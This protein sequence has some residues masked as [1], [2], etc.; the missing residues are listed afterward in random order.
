VQGR[1]PWNQPQLNAGGQRCR[2]RQS[3]AA[4]VRRW[5]TAKQVAGGTAG[6]G[7]SVKLQESTRAESELSFF[8]L[9]RIPPWA[10]AFAAQWSL[11]GAHSD[12]LSCGIKI[13][14]GS[15]DFSPLGQLGQAHLATLG[16]V[17]L[18]AQYRS[19]N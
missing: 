1:R 12:F 19:A 4:A 9:G 13:Q 10:E 17:A 11:S 15:V 7:A 18:L 8:S 5:H 16:P 3:D 2:Q 14:G 6:A